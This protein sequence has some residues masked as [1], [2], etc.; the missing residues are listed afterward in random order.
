LSSITSNLAAVIA[1]LN[2]E[3]ADPAQDPAAALR[4]LRLPGKAR[5]PYVDVVHFGASDLTVVARTL[6]DE[7][8][9]LQSVVAR[10]DEA[11]AALT[12]VEEILTEAGELVTA[13]SKG[14]GRGQRKTNQK[15]VDVLLA[16]LE[17][18]TSKASKTKPELF[19][20]S[21]AL[22]AGGVSINIEDISR[23]SLG[24]SLMNGRVVNL[25][26]IK[27]RG[28]LDSAK[29]RSMAEGARKALAAAKQT[30]T[31]LREKVQKFESETIRPRVGDVANALAGLFN[32]ASGLGTSEVAIKTARELRE[33]TLASST[34]AIAVGADGWDRERVLDLL[35]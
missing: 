16:E 8:E 28:G 23:E 30:V 24:R 6:D 15:K 34:A 11:M 33:I 21:A 17:E 29:R 2:A 26:D 19:G 1:S 18:V 31:E 20:G 32:D 3:K 10:A 14:A 13:N 27:T 5:E 22:S 35:T 9:K 4:R 7:R 25:D 12:R